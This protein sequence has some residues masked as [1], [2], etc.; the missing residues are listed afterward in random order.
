MVRNKRREYRGRCAA[1]LQRVASKPWESKLS[2]PFAFDKD[3]TDLWVRLDYSGISAVAAIID[4]VP[5][6]YFG[7][8][9]TAYVRV[10]RAIKWHEHADHPVTAEALREALQQFHNNTFDEV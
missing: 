9:K 8:E 6:T 5:V 10:S 2:T 1:S 7:D 4:G 3:K